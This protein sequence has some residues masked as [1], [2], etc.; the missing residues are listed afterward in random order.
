MSGGGGNVDYPTRRPGWPPPPAPGE[1]RAPAEAAVNEYLADLLADY[2]RRDA[3][4]VQRHLRTVQQAVEKETEGTTE[5]MFGGSVGKH[6]YVDGISDVDALLVVNES[7]LADAS[8]AQVLAY[9]EARLKERLPDSVVE[10]GDLSVKVKFADGTHLQLLPAIRT[11]TGV[12]IATPGGKQ[13][14][15][16]VRPAEFAKKLASVNQ[17]NG[18]GVVP[19]IKLLKGLQQASLPKANQLAGYHIESLAIEAFR[20]YGGRLTRRDMLLHLVR[21]AAERVR[22]PIADSTGQSL[23]VDDYLGAAESADRQRVAA[24]LDRLAR[25]LEGTDPSGWRTAFG[26]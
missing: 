25:K 3:A 2:S 1:R 7:G 9:V 14:S 23:H 17:A 11:A 24:S 8:P 20:D 10:A 15:P 5:V 19:A 22:R 6:T 26:E 13:W 21:A 18:R 16:V 12:R 4:G